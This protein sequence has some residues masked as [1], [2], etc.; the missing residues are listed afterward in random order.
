[1]PPEEEIFP[2]KANDFEQVGKEFL[3]CF[4]ELGGLRSDARVLDVG[5]G[6]GRMAIPLTQYLDHNGSYEGLDV[7]SRGIEWCQEHITP[8]YPNFRF[9]L[10]DIYNKRYNSKGRHQAQDYEFPYEDR[11]FDFVYLISVFTHMLPQE[12]DNYLSE[13]ARVL[14]P[15]GR[16]MITYFLLNEESLKLIEESQSVYNF[17]PAGGVYRVADPQ[18][19]ERA[20]AY[21]EKHVLHLYKKH[22]L[23]PIELPAYGSWCGRKSFLRYQDMI[24]AARN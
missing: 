21:D 16:C 23:S 1:V 10:A 9:R 19:P 8:R 15:G 14:K 3:R 5:C 4:K 20:V 13:V 2:G 17:E 7:V 22:C 24:V 6:I 11:S 18:E 12:V